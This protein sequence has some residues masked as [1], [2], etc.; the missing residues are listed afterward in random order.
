M[1]CVEVA[2]ILCALFYSFLNG[3]LVPFVLIVVR[4]L[5]IICL[6]T[7]MSYFFIFR[8]KMDPDPHCKACATVKIVV[9]S[10]LLIISSILLKYVYAL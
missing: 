1:F 5:S 3:F 4:Y 9:G 8:F 6:V 7:G 2:I 10:A